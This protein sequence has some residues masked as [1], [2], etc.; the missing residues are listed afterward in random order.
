MAA[1]QVYG[2]NLVSAANRTIYVASPPSAMAGAGSYVLGFAVD[3]G[4]WSRLPSASDLC[5][6]ADGG[7]FVGLPAGIAYF[8]KN[9]EVLNQAAW[10]PVSYPREFARGSA[11][12]AALGSTVFLIG[13]RT[14]AGVG[15]A[16]VSS[17]DVSAPA[18]AQWT[19]LGLAP[20]AF[21]GACAGTD[22]ATSTIYVFGGN[23]D[24]GLRVFATVANAWSLL[25]AR[26]DYSGQC[27]ATSVPK[28]RNSFVVAEPASL[29]LFDLTQ[30]TWSS[31]AWLPATSDP[32]TFV[33][34]VPS[35]GDLYLVGFSGPSSTI[36][37][38]KWNL[39]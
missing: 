35:T 6:C 29:S 2:P 21:V 10:L 33:A 25:P 1:A 11:A 16:T 23:S 19:G 8:G 20:F 3:T 39:Q 36:T 32:Q 30:L 27:H 37:I 38:Y 31:K 7:S 18:T 5:T 12:A 13:G 34:V 15:T 14:A 26:S 22:P 4:T 9:A 24:G 17:V 28:W